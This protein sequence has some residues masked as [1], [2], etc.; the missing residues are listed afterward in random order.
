LREGGRIERQE[1][2]RKTLQ[3]LFKLNLKE[4]DAYRLRRGQMRMLRGALQQANCLRGAVVIVVVVCVAG[5]RGIGGMRVEVMPNW[6]MRT[7]SVI[8]VIGC[9]LEMVK[10]MMHPVRRRRGE[11]KNKTGN[12]NQSAG[13][14]KLSEYDLPNLASPRDCTMPGARVV[15]FTFD[16]SVLRVVSLLMTS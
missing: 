3:S 15:F 6:W 9:F 1:Q 5:L 7:M 14:A 4:N 11:K 13:R 16:H 10:K 12:D 8:A 2:E